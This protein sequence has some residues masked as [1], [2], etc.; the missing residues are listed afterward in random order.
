MGRVLDRGLY[1][2]TRNDLD[3]LLLESVLALQVILHLRFITELT[4][5]PL[6]EIAELTTMTATAAAMMMS[7][8]MTKALRLEGVGFMGQ[9]E[10]LRKADLKRKL[11]DDEAY[12]AAVEMLEDVVKEDMQEIEEFIERN[13][14]LNEI[15]LF[16]RSWRVGDSVKKFRS[17]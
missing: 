4:N 1:S 16:C 7:T 11:V 14:W 2:E 17:V 15:L 8:T 12:R 13:N 10:E 5:N 3:E 9:Y 6:D